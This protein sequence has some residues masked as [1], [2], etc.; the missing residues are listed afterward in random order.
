MDK[1]EKK[2][3]LPEEE[4]LKQ[5]SALPKVKAPE[6][7][8]QKV[9]ER[10]ERRSAFEKIMRALFVPV[11]IKVP[12]ELAAMAAAIV[13]I[14]ST[15]GIKKPVEQLVCIP[16][17]KTATGTGVVMKSELSFGGRSAGVE[18]DKKEIDMAFINKGSSDSDLIGN[19]VAQAPSALPP[20]AENKPIEIALLVRTEELAKARD[21]QK[22]VTMDSYVSRKFKDVSLREEKAV[23]PEA[24]MAISRKPYLTE[25]L[26]KVRNQVELAQGKVTKTEVNK[27]T[28]MPQY[29]DA[30]IPA[31][32]YAKFVEN[33]SGIGVLQEPLLKEAPQG[34]DIVQVRIKLISKE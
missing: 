31:A 28:G 14:I 10:I 15:V 19:V 5:M 18:G 9:R 4:Y 33:L 16:Q 23:R 1:R 11:K 32:G 26:S 24:E 27:D 30:E 3:L 25:A 21:A 34:R 2:N 22:S 20:P 13:L 12:L 29:V 17:A 7:F 6:D 8:L